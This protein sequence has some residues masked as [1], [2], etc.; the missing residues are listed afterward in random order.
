MLL[1]LGAY[2]LVLARSSARCATAPVIAGT[3]APSSIFAPLRLHIDHQPP[4]GRRRRL[5]LAEPMEEILADFRKTPARQLAG[6][7]RALL[8]DVGIMWTADLLA[9]YAA[10]GIE[11]RN[12][13]GIDGRIVDPQRRAVPVASDRQGWA[14][15]R[16]RN[17]PDVL[18]GAALQH[19]AEMD[20]AGRR[21]FRSIGSMGGDLG[22]PIADEAP[23][24]L[25]RRRV[26]GVGS[27]RVQQSGKVGQVDLLLP[28]SA[29]RAGSRLGEN[30]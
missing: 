20:F 5:D 11:P 3:A 22:V 15:S 30:C 13:P 1:V 19:P 27:V 18:H 17:D 6:F 10:A 4:I 16:A 24:K 26:L 25:E 12:P 2:H 7:G 14:A 23:I 21:V 9:E 8:H 29:R 28:R